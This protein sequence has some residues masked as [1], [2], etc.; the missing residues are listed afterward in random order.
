MSA[1]A[2]TSNCKKRF[3]LNIS[4][5]AQTTTASLNKKRGRTSEWH[6]S[7]VVI[8]TTIRQRINRPFVLCSP[9]NRTLGSTGLRRGSN[10][11]SHSVKASIWILCH[12][13]T[14]RPTD[15]LLVVYNSPAMFLGIMIQ[16]F[17][18]F[19]S[20]SVFFMSSVLRCFRFSICCIFSCLLLQIHVYSVRLW[21]F[22]A[23]KLLSVWGLSGIHFVPFMNPF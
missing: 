15:T 1:K 16:Y 3:A 22:R 6:C 9:G 5:G 13:L 18:S 4:H 19:I 21:G 2:S 14:H 7:L 8:P 20:L 12:I 11:I 17:N 23:V 10:S